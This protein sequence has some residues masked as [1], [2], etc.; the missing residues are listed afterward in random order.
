MKLIATFFTI[1]LLVVSLS[2]CATIVSKSKYPVTISSTPDGANIT[3]VD[4]SSQTVFIGKTPTT[5]TLKAGYEFFQKATYRITFDK[6]GYTK[7]IVGIEGE[8]DNW[9][10]GNFCVGGFG[11][12][13]IDPL[14]GSMW[15]LDEN[16]HLTL[17]P[18]PTLSAK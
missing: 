14:S 10:I 16:V 1:T 9:Y 11:F 18:L 8:L 7:Q 12:I 17:S 13:L 6:S 3:V 2:G 15:K 4:R 5:V